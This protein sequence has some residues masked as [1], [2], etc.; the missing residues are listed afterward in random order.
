MRNKLQEYRFEAYLFTLALV[1]FGGLVFPEQAFK[2]W[3]STTSITLNIAAGFILISVRKKALI[4]YSI[5]LAA[6]FVFYALWLFDSSVITRGLNFARLGFYSVF[7]TIVTVELILQVWKIQEVN[8]TVIMG[9]MSGY[10]SLGLISF[11]L[12]YGIAVADPGAYSGISGTLS[13]E[14]PEE[15]MYFSFISLMTIGYGDIVPV[16][17]I[18][19]KAVVLVGLCGQFYMVIFSAVVLGKYI[20]AQQSS[21]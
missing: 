3:I 10:I 8:W 4:Y 5:L 7:Y 9:L 17:N 21:K 16:T 15:L 1:L 11:F 2:E 14:Y 12:L 18:S 20:A 19:Q 6:G 13:Q